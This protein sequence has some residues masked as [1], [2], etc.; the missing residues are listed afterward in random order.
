[1]DTQT[2]TQSFEQWKRNVD[3]IIQRKTGLSAD[4]LPDYCYRDA[5]EDDL[6]ALTAAN[7]AIMAACEGY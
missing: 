1:M 6:S 4:D 3:L 2:T 5:Y 7:R